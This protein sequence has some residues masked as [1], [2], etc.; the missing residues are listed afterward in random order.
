MNKT[1]TMSFCKIEV[2]DYQTLFSESPEVYMT[3]YRIYLFGDFWAIIR[4]W[5]TN[6][7]NLVITPCP[8]CEQR[9]KGM[10]RDTI[11][12]RF[13]ETFVEDSNGKHIDSEI[14]SYCC[15]CKDKQEGLI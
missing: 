3:E 12:R 4:A 5:K 14:Q 6:D 13:Y 11:V 8:A 2:F 10:R 1:E 15:L 9:T 7:V